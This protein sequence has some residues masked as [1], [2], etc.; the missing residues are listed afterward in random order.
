MDYHINE[1]LVTITMDDGKA[2]VVGPAF[3]QAMNA[4]L[5]RALAEGAVAVILRGREGMFS[6][7]FDLAEFEKGLEEGLAMVK[8]GF[9]LLIRLYS[10]ELPLV[11]ASTGHCIAMGAFLTMAC[12][13][14]VGTAGTFKYR[15][16][17]TA[18]GMELPPLLRELARDRIVKQH[19]TRV[20]LLAETYLAGDALEAG[21]ID[22]LCSE[23]DLQERSE[24]VARQLAKLPQA[25]FAKNKI[26]LRSQTLATMRD[27][28]ASYG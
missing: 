16:P 1:G 22:E 2:N 8:G 6:G 17:E 24:A 11:A 15:L 3:I 19:F 28:L 27:N 13:M 10:F 18:I 25:Q 5:D 14:R 20:A 21:F 7:G 12:D 26:D 9:A 4:A 23:E